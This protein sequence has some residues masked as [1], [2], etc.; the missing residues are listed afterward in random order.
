MMISTVH[1]LLFAVLLP[2]PVLLLLFLKKTKQPPHHLPPSPFKLPIIGNLHQLGH[3]PHRSLHALSL[4]YGPLMLLK[5][6]QQTT[7]TLVVSSAEMARK[8]MKTHDVAFSNRPPNPI[9][10]KLMYG[11]DIAFAP[12][13]EYWRQARRIC[14]LQLLGSKQVELFRPVREEE[15]AIGID[16]LRS[17]AA[18]KVPINL[19]EAVVAI[20]K[21][22]ASRAALGKEYA[23]GGGENDAKE[24]HRLIREFQDLL[25]TLHVADFFPWLG[26][27][28]RFNGLDLRVDKNFKEWDDLL[29]K[30]LK[31]HESGNR[32]GGDHEGVKDFVD[33]LL[34]VQKDG[35]AGIPF[36]QDHIKAIVLVFL[37]HLN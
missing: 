3:L 18:A 33:V 26:W 20:T 9:S 34:Q 12:Y 35:S 1:S 5:L 30:I 37:C 31:D 14:V 15:T 19:S 13:G 25:G 8:I 27:I 21:S 36:T 6:G 11:K 7:P 10:Q 23:V 17:A 29:T 24:I 28:R 4:K 2:L 16:K 32:E 22:V